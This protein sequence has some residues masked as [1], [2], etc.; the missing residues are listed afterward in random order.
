MRDGLPDGSDTPLVTDAAALRQP[1]YTVLAD[2]AERERARAI[3]EQALREAQFIGENVWRG[4]TGARTAAASA[5]DAAPLTM[6][7]VAM[8]TKEQRWALKEKALRD[9][10]EADENAWRSGNE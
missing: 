3:K 8:M 7:E 10:A 4:N 1:G 2:A 9:A 5:H 6:D